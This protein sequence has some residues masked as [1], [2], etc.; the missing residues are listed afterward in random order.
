MN[1]QKLLNMTIIEYENL[2]HKIGNAILT[3]QVEESLKNKIMHNFSFFDDWLIN[4]IAESNKD[5]QNY[6]RAVWLHSEFMHEVRSI[7]E[8]AENDYTE[9]AHTR[10]QESSKYKMLSKKLILALQKWQVSLNEA[11]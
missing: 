6:L 10:L 8:D 5:N 4:D 1:I 2:E 11:S 7:L 9:M 3:N